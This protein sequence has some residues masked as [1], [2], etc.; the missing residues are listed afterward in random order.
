[1]ARCEI[2]GN[3]YDKSFEL[4]AGGVRHVF[5]SFECAIHALAPVCQ[6]CGCRVIGHGTEAD[7][8]FYCC[9]HCARESGA[10]E[11]RDRV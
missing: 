7:G 5:D 9:A 4:M 10:S 2:C 11:A 6:H 8:R 1:M 3:D